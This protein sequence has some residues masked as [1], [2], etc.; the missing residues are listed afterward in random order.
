MRRVAAGCFN[1]LPV[2]S[3]D[4]TKIVFMHADT[5]NDDGDPVSEQVWIMDANGAHKH[6]LTFDALQKDQVP[7]W[8][9]DGSK[10]AY[11]PA[12]P[13]VAAPGS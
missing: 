5:S 2:W 6:P 11:T 8:S 13:A 9:P 1:E 3:P 10:I 12:T 4:G 7:D